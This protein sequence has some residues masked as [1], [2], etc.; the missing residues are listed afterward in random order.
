MKM[1]KWGEKNEKKQKKHSNFWNL[2]NDTFRKK[3]FEEESF[4]SCKLKCTE[5]EQT[6]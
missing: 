4:D 3:S 2:V 1:N 6:S 5:A